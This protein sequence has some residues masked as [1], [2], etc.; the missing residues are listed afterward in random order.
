MVKKILAKFIS[1]DPSKVKQSQ[2]MLMGLIFIGLILGIVIISK[3]VQ[4][5]SI[6][7]KKADK[8]E[9]EGLKIQLASNVVDGNKVWGEYFEMQLKQEQELRKIEHEKLIN[10]FKKID[11]ERS[12]KHAQDIE[13][14]ENQ[15]QM[16][17]LNL[18][19]MFEKDTPPVAIN[20]LESSF[21]LKD[22]AVSQDTGFQDLPKDI[23]LYIPASTYVKG[24][25]LS[26][27]SV[28]TGVA[29]QSNPVP[30]V[31]R[32][33][34]NANLPRG[35]QTDL[36][37]CRV[38][39]SGYGD[40]S[41]ERVM[42]RLEKLACVDN[43]SKRSVETK[44]AGFV[45]GQDGVN[46]IRGKVVS[47]DAKHLKNA[48]IGGF[49]SGLS[50]AARQEGAFSLN[51]SVGLVQEKETFGSSLKDGSIS[52]VGSATEKIANYY[53]QRAESISPVIEVPAGSSVDIV[54]TEGVYYGQQDTKQQIEGTRQ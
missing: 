36:K 24:R 52:G 34:D 1:S 35:H 3:V 20:N 14:L 51:P 4:I 42:I 5:L 6:S 22:V 13:R 11:E 28:S 16:A 10:E 48:A 44:I 23:S 31:I 39:A 41:S 8:D 53:I 26:G 29:V 27:I 40:L 45:V 15:L 43:Q 33:T 49:L 7:A 37:D 17:E 54:F 50:K 19:S 2:Y 32:L 9:N 30:I 21:S 47:M 46:G 38:I 12:V 25:L 18:R